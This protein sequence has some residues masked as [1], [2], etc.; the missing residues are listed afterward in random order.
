MG[1]DPGILQKT[2]DVVNYRSMTK[3]IDL[4]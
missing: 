1:T 2:F 4:L 3:T